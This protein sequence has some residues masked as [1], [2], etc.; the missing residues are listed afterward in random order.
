MTAITF[1]NQYNT[2]RSNTQN[3]AGKV[4]TNSHSATDEAFSGITSK[5]QN[6]V[7]NEQSFLATAQEA[8]TYQ[9]LGVDKEKIDQIKA[10]LEELAEALQQTEADA[11]TIKAKMDELQGMLEQEY[12]QGRERMQASA[13]RN[14]GI[15]ISALV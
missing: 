11:D 15:I 7:Q 3:E 4:A 2:Y 6:P 14:K 1:K 9:R 8:L 12:Q 10:T 5:L 13:K